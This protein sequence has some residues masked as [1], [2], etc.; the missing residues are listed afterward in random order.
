M[1]QDRN[2]FIGLAIK[3]KGDWRKIYQ[4]VTSKEIEEVD[5]NEFNEL[6]KGLD[7]GVITILDKNYPDCLL[8]IFQ[9][10]FVLFYYG[11]IN[12][13]NNISS[14]LGVIG[15]REPTAKAL[16]KTR[17]IIKE[18]P[19][20]IVIVSGLAAGIDGCAH[21]AALDYGHKTIAVLGCGV[22]VCY[23]SENQELMQRI[24]HT[25][26]SLIISEYPPGT[27][28]SQDKF[29]IRN[30]LITGL[31]S[32]ILITEAKRRSGTS[33]TAS[34]ALDTGKEVLCLPSSDWGDSLCNNLLKDGGIPVENA[35]EVNEYFERRKLL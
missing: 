22:N 35:Q 23:P 15:T 9:P 29:P 34:Y 26:G 7:C 5:E 17:E 16:N 11:N 19:K 13:I 21:E 14:N 28:P 31:S 18:L 2:V 1:I 12:L 27:L 25:R 32:R 3:Y 10:P 8:H 4:I 6:I 24:R 30:R 20:D 33:I